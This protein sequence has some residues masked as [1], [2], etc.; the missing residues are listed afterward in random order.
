VPKKVTLKLRQV[1]DCDEFDATNS[2]TYQF[3]ILESESKQKI[4]E[5]KRDDP[6][7]LLSFNDKLQSV[8]DLDET[9]TTRPDSSAPACG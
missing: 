2:N 5:E 4:K 9:T 6:L 7:Y 1:K 8:L 3:H